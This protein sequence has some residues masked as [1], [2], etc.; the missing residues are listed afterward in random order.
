MA[1]EST[2]GDTGVEVPKAKRVVPGRREGELAVGGDDDVRYK[3]V[4]A[5]EDAFG[6][7]V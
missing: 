6:V 2:G 5:V 3:V 1:N 4:M 7:P